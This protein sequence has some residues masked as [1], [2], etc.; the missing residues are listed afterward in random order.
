MRWGNQVDMAFYIRAL[1]DEEP[2]HSSYLQ[3][4]NI[5]HFAFDNSRIINVTKLWFWELFTR[6]RYSAVS[7]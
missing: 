2:R 6:V 4:R 3:K 5:T 1:L 7:N